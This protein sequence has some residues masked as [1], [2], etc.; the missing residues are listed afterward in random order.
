MANDFP[1][2][3]D[4]PVTNH[5]ILPEPLLTI[6]K[7]HSPAGTFAPGA[8]VSYTVTVENIGAA[9]ATNV[10]VTGAPHATTDP[11]VA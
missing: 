3:V 7:G 9:P 4:T 2:T 8:T 10:V 6:T 5:F 1:G 11:L